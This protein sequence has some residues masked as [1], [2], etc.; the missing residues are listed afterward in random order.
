[1][2]VRQAGMWNVLMSLGF[3]I[4]IIL[5]SLAVEDQHLVRTAM[6][7]MVGIWFIP[8]VWLAS[9]SQR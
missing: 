4:A 8:F 7:V 2:S 3:A 5:M 1:M 6:L 9:R